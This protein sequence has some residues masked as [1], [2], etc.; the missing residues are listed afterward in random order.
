VLYFIARMKKK[1]TLA[2]ARIDAG[3]SQSDVGVSLGVSQVWISQVERGIRRPSARRRQ[4]F[5]LVLGVPVEVLFPEQA[6]SG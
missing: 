3:F 1:S 4:E 5:A 2:M 6:T